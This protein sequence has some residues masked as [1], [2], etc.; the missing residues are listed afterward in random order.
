MNVD[1]D[2]GLT[3]LANTNDADDP[4]A[5]HIGHFIHRHSI[6]E[7]LEFLNR[8]AG[9]LSWVRLYP[10]LFS[11]VARYDER[12]LRRLPTSPRASLQEEQLDVQRHGCHGPGAH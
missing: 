11:E 3:E 2:E 6:D 8:L 5:T 7:F 9:R 12:A 1:T 4:H 10:P